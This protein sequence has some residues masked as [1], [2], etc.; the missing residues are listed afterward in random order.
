MQEIKKIVVPVDFGEH[1][2][3]LVEF[4]TYVADK[5]S[6]RLS[7]FH[8]AKLYET[9][10]EVELVA[11]PSVQQ[12]EKE[13]WDHAE[14]KMTELVEGCTAKSPGCTGKV[15]KGDVVSEVIAF[16]KQ[17]KADLIIIGTHGAKRLE[18]VL[19]GS[20]ARRVVKRAPCPVLTFNPYK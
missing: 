5:F 20:V 8:V 2:D 15:G 6:A 18:E 17:E 11:F 4:A 1:S 3:K 14:R 9:Y 10:V 16:A 7:F 19:L 12:A 13:I